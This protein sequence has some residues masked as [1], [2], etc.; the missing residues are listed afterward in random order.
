MMIATIPKAQ[1]PKK[2]RLFSPGLGLGNEG[3][4]AKA[5]QPEERGGDPEVAG[6]PFPSLQGLNSWFEP[7]LARVNYGKAC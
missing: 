1:I 6:T 5:D 3:K 2:G 7:I 4:P